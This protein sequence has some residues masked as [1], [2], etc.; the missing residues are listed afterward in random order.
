MPFLTLPMAC[1]G[2]SSPTHVGMGRVHYGLAMAAHK[3]T[4]LSFIV[5]TFSFVVQVIF[6]AKLPKRS[7]TNRGLKHSN[8]LISEGW[9][10]RRR[11]RKNEN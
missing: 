8:K 7:K 9:N 6:D 11:E 2:A 1:R 4:D 5:N 3:P 10:S